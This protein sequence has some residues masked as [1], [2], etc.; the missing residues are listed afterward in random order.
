MASGLKERKGRHKEPL[1]LPRHGDRLLAAFRTGIKNRSLQ[2]KKPI[3]KQYREKIN[4]FFPHFFS[5]V[6][7]RLTEKQRQ[8]EKG[9]YLNVLKTVSAVER[10]ELSA[11]QRTALFMQYI[12]FELQYQSVRWSGCGLDDRGDIS[13]TGGWG[14]FSFKP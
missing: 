8:S 13:G 10:T 9:K 12:S 3:S 6:A 5:Y 14:G 7:Q 4:Y 1:F 11:A 2:K